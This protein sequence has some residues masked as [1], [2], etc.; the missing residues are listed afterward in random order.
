MSTNYDRNGTGFVDIVFAVRNWKN[1][2]ICSK[3]RLYY[4][5]TK[6]AQGELPKTSWRIIVTN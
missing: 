3:I 5:E 4:Y 6:L 2:Y 1:M